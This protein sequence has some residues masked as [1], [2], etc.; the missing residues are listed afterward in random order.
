MIRPRCSSGTRDGSSGPAE[1]KASSAPPKALASGVA[2]GTVAA[3]ASSTMSQHRAYSPLWICGASVA[4]LA[5]RLSAPRAAVMVMLSTRRCEAVA[6]TYR[7][8][9]VAGT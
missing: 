1:T 8:G 6:G 7:R 5:K 2:S 9:D 3:T 4:Y